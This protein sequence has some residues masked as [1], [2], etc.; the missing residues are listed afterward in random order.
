MPN[1]LVADASSLIALERRNLVKAIPQLKEQCVI[2]LAVKEE[3]WPGTKPEIFIVVKVYELTK[4][5]LKKSRD[6]E[7]KGIGKGEAQCCA[8]ALRLGSNFIVCDDQKFIRQRFFIRDEDLQKIKIFG[9]AFFLHL[10]HQQGIINDV[11]SYYT[12]I[13]SLCNWERSEVQVANYTFLKEMGY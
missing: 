1:V 4:R 13:I 10:F 12:D 9:F 7:K 3:L 5:T 11:W 8:L 2:P 6:F